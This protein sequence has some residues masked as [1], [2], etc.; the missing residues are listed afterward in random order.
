MNRKQHRPFRTAAHKLKEGGKTNISSGK[1]PQN[2]NIRIIKLR[3]TQKSQHYCI[4]KEKLL[5]EKDAELGEVREELREAGQL[6]DNKG[7]QLAKIEQQLQ[8]LQQTNQ[9]LESTNRLVVDYW[10]VFF[11]ELIL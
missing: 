6:T 1:Y 10:N 2:P 7:E 3:N 5:S 11:I 9:Q 8:Q 4:L